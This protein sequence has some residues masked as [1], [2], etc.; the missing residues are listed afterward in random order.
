MNSTTAKQPRAKVEAGNRPSSK[1]EIE[2]ATTFRWCEALDFDERPAAQSWFSSIS[3]T[4][5]KI[6]RRI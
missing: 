3:S 1:R 2:L 5:F 4:R 6:R